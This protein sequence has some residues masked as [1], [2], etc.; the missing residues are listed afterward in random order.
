M[1]LLTKWLPDHRVPRIP[2]G[3]LSRTISG[4]S[5]IWLRGH[6]GIV[7]GRVQIQRPAN[8]S[9]TSPLLISSQFLSLWP[10]LCTCVQN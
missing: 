4:V 2:F 5:G 9:S 1:L 3:V 6:D 10:T 8:Y 7:R